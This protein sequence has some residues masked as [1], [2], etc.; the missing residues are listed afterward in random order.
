MAPGSAPPLSQPSPDVCPDCGLSARELR[1]GG[2]MG[3]PAC[4]G[5]LNGLVEEAARELH[6]VTAA[7]GRQ[8]KPRPDPAEI[9]ASVSAPAPAP[10]AAAAAPGTTTAEPDR[11]LPWPTRRAT[12]RRPDDAP[13]RRP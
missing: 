12:A 10:A 5:A 2:L 7:G 1:D 6:G 3:C 8:P 11:S 13:P 4:Y 9:E